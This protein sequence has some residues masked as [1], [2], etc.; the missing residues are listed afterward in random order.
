MT[1]IDCS[2]V[3]YREGS[4]GDSEHVMMFTARLSTPWAALH[5][6]VN[7]DVAPR[8]DAQFAKHRPSS[9]HVCWSDLRVLAHRSLGQQA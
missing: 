5:V 3:L 8:D 2:W 7:L 6:H 1:G 9:L 4:E